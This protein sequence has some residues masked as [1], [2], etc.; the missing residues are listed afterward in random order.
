MYD[1]LGLGKLKPTKMVLKFIDHSTRLPRGMVEDVLIKVGEFIFLVDF[2]VLKMEG[3]MSTENKISIILSRP[4][5][6]T[7][8]ARINC[9]DGKLKLTFGSMT[10]ELN[11]F[12]IQK[13]P[14]VLIMLTI[15]PLI[16]WVTLHWGK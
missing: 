11:V 8:K 14:M 4:F 1:K 10:M 13:Q 16:G 7:S 15:N 12:N 9:R 5:S 3:V 6:A 2:L